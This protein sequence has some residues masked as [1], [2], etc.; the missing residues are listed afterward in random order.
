[1][2]MNP[3]SYPKKPEERVEPPGAEIAGSCELLRVGAEKWTQTQASEERGEPVLHASTYYILGLLGDCFQ[4]PCQ[5]SLRI[6][7][8][9]DLNNH[10]I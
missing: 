5:K 4:C 8:L 9:I 10:Q 6:Y 2:N 1:M 7:I 3:V